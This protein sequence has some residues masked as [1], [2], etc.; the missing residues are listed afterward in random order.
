MTFEELLKRTGMLVYS[1]RGVSM[2]PLLRQERD[3]VVIRRT[4]RYGKYDVVLFLRG[5]GQHVLHRILREETDRFWIVGDN[6][7]SGEWIPKER[8][9][10]TMTGVVRD[11]EEIALGGFW[12]RVYV[13]LWI[14]PWPLRFGVLRC[15]Y[16]ARRCL[17]A[18]WRRVKRLRAER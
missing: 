16:W 15:R 12:Y 4:E 17:G 11:R 6:C 2:Q 9:L 1:I 5:N 18:I 14:A 10:G 13:A 3:V 7:F 8:V